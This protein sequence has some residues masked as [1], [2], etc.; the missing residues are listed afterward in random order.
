M[1]DICLQRSKNSA[2]IKDEVFFGGGGV[3]EKLMGSK[4]A[5]ISV[6][7]IMHNTTHDGE[8][9]VRKYT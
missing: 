9:I 1:V 3:V 2:S 8:V 5:L 6:E 4:D 7:L